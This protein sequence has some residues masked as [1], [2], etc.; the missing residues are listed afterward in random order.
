MSSDKD[1]A[2]APNGTAAAGHADDSAELQTSLGQDE[3]P[4]H[5]DAE[6]AYLS[7]NDWVWHG[8]YDNS[9]SSSRVDKL[10][11]GPP[12][13]LL[14]GLSKAR[15]KA[16]GSGSKSRKSNEGGNAIVDDLEIASSEDDESQMHG[17]PRTWLS[18]GFSLSECASGLCVKPPSEDD[19]SFFAWS[20]Q[21]Q[22]NVPP[23]PYHCR[24]LTAIMSVVTATILTGASI[25]AGG[26][27][28]ASARTPFYQL[29]KEE[30]AREY[31]ARLSDALS[32]LLW[33]AVQAS[34]ARKKLALKAVSS[35]VE[36]QVAKNDELQVEWNRLQYKLGLI[37]TCNWNADPNTGEIRIEDDTPLQLVT[38]LIHVE[39]VKCYVSSNIKMFLASGGVALFL[40]TLLKIHGKGA[41]TKMLHRSEGKSLIRC[42]CEERHTRKLQEI[43]QRNLLSGRSAP[44]LVVPSSNALKTDTTPPGSECI[45]VEMISLLL[46]G[47]IHSSWRG[48][49]TGPLEFGLLTTPTTPE[50]F[51]DKRLSRPKKP[52]WILL[53]PTCY[54]VVYTVGCPEQGSLFAHHDVPGTVAHMRHFNSWYGQRRSTCF[55]LTVG[56]SDDSLSTDWVKGGTT[57]AD[58]HELPSVR[59]LRE[60]MKARAQAEKDRYGA[61]VVSP[62]LLF[63]QQELDGVV[64]HPDDPKFYPNQFKLWRYDICPTVEAGDDENQDQKRRA[65]TWTPYCRLASRGKLLVEAKLGPALHRILLTRWPRTSVFDRFEPSDP[66]PVV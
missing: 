13:D 52:V 22:R 63:T 27:T 36:K 17:V 16:C 38:S 32:A 42:T 39:D 66:D 9:P 56:R 1:A 3:E 48:W 51:V 26:V 62:E 41:I 57:V 34:V 18:A 20:R 64:A 60:R 58:I 53:G 21:I 14:W 31:E 35:S 12:T 45:S 25:Q 50:F 54:S 61:E 29:N 55:R 19:L 46:T 47:K 7:D 30:R 4:C 23:P 28:T 6:D 24:S 40:E 11:M 15:S 44:A 8:T 10:S 5:R 43:R 37:P 59:L 49:D 33:I 65:Q 2:G